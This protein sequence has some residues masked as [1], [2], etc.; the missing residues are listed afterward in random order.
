VVFNGFTKDLIR[1]HLR[2]YQEIIRGAAC[3]NEVLFFQIEKFKD[4][5]IGA[6]LQTFWIPAN[7]NSISY[8]DTQ[9]KYDNLY[10]YRAFAY[11]AVVGN[12]YTFTNL[13]NLAH[14]QKTG[15]FSAE[16]TIENRCSMKLVKIPLFQ[17]QARVLNPPPSIPMI[18]FYNRSDASNM[19]NIRMAL[20]SY[21]G[22]GAYVR[23]TDDDDFVITKLQQ[24]YKNQD[25]HGM[26]RPSNSVGVFEIFR[27]STAPKSYQDFSRYKLIEIM[28]EANTTSQMFEDKILPNTKYYYCFRS[29]NHHG[30]KSLPTKVM[31]VE[32][33][34]DAD[35]SK[36][37][38]SIYEFPKSDPY[39]QTTTMKR[40]FQ[41][42]PSANQT[43][44]NPEQ[45]SIY[46]AKSLNNKLNKINLGMAEKPIWGRKMK[47][48][49]TSTDTGRKIDFNITF[50]LI[51]EK[52]EE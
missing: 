52:S 49:L 28:S 19:V 4:V 43:Y 3:E 29:V 36:V 26:A 45:N 21:Y 48:R 30:I 13:E 39:Q 1:N 47:I 2:S 32:L 44:F 25:S 41:V 38:V 15:R 8:I 51:K 37:E 24:F 17:E 42:M 27:T 14:N 31:E 34:K 33:I 18:D 40:F 11:V 9:L 10:V 16:V 50:D 12:S 5:A 22:V 7:S 46:G 6:P 23:I 35:D 20:T